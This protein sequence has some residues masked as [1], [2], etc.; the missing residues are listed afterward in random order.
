MINIRQ[1]TYADFDAVYTL[2]KAAF[3]TAQHSDG[4]EQ[5]LVVKLRQS[6]AFIP[7][8]SLIAEADGQIVG[9]ILLTKISI[10]DSSG[11]IALALAPLAVAPDYQ[12]QGIGGQLIQTAHT[13][14]KA[15]GYHYSVLLG[16]PD[17]YQRFGYV[18]A[19]NFGI[20][21]PFD[22]PAGYYMAYAL[23]NNPNTVQGI[24]R[25]DGAFGI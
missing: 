22:A 4:T 24:V 18:P 11:N 25:Y 8:L 1:E 6:S 12:R 23:Q 16:E 9:H 10:G 5:D 14:A 19:D 7:E 20:I 2:I 15:L 21:A 13:I 17:Y 3:A